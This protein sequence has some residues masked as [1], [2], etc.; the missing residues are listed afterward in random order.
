MNKGTHIIV[1]SYVVIAI[2]IVVDK[3]VI[4]VSIRGPLGKFVFCSR[5][6]VKV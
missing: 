1:I 6:R 2:N 3:I 4:I 5:F